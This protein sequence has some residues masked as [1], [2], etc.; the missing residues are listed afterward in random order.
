MAQPQYSPI[1]P[2][3]NRWEMPVPMT[4]EP[5]SMCGP[6]QPQEPPAKHS[7]ASV[8]AITPETLQRTIYERSYT[9]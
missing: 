2:L 9:M 6:F 5:E 7:T 4:D 8:V 1:L 3:G